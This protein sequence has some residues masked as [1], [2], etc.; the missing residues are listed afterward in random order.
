MSGQMIIPTAEPFFFPGGPTGC[1]L[2][3]GFTGS[4]K[5]MRWMGE[6]LA[7][8]GHTVLGI[9]LAGH[10]TQPADLVRT[11]WRDWLASVEDGIHLL[12]PVTKHLYMIGLSMGGA[13]A[14]LAA[15]RYPVSGAIAMS[16]PYSLKADWRLRYTKILSRIQPEVDKGPSDWHNPAAALDHVD[17]PRYPT[18]SVGELHQLLGVVQTEIPKIQVPVL[19]IHSHQDKGVAPEN[20]QKIYNCLTTSHKEMFWVEDSSHIVTRDP[21]REKV[22]QTAAQFIERV[23]AETARE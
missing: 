20:M 8:Q 23:N 10:A 14:L 1:L 18:L 12:K 11:R 19:L 17:Y 9:R 13:L 3:H 7:R 2:I 22:F 16:T 4:P 15:A 5:E 6:Y 21:E